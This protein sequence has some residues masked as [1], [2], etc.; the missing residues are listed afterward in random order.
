L[1]EQL[2]N[3][4]LILSEG[5]VV[6]ITV[7][8]GVDQFSP[9]Q[10]QTQEQFIACVDDLLYQAKGLG[11]NCVAHPDI[12]EA[13]TTQVTQAEKDILFGVFGDRDDTEA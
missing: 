6:N 2:A 12:Q 9:P 8:L 1:R 3:S 5:D 4:P 10:M 7:S 11:R 13:P